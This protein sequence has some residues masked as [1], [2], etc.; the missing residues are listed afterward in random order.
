MVKFVESCVVFEEI[1]V[2]VSLAVSISNCPFRCPKCHSPYLQEDCGVE[3]NEKIIDE[4]LEKNKGVNCFLFMGD[5][6]DVNR[7]Y[8]LAMYIRETHPELKTAVYMGSDYI[9]NKYL[10]CFDY[11]KTG[12][13]IEK[14]GPLN[15]VTTNQRLYENNG[16]LKDI[17]YKFWR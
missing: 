7:V 6:G 5:G 2:C 16:G 15:K 11:I 14:L 8:D 10:E 13:Y 9:P 1:P 17:T 12:S 3:L 4:L